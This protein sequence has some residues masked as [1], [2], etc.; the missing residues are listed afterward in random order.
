MEEAAF[1]EMQEHGFKA[2]PLDKRIF[3]SMGELGRHVNI[4]EYL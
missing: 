1:K 2:K 4:Y 3:R